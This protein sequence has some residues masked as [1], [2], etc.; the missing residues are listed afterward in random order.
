MQQY[1]QL[2]VGMHRYRK[3]D[4]YTKTQQM[5]TKYYPINHDF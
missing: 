4:A 3:L 5:A 1:L 2:H